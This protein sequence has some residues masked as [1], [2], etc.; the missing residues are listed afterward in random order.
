[1]CSIIVS[2]IFASVSLSIGANFE[3]EL[4]M[5]NEE[6]NKKEEAQNEESQEQV[7]S[8]R[9]FFKEAGKKML[10]MIGAAVLSSLPF[11]ECK[12]QW[13]CNYSC[14]SGCWGGCSGGCY[15][16]CDTGCDGGCKGTCSGTC[17]HI[18]ATTLLR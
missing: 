11:S 4:S 7:Q 14:S 16:S 13:G 15:R 2:C 12:A 8:R 5:K 17:S 18:G 10:P 9:D 6:L 3:N 1:M